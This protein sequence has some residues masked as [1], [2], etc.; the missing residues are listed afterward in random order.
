MF[1]A[2]LAAAARRD[3]KIATI[4][5]RLIKVD[6][7]QLQMGEA[8]RDLPKQIRVLERLA[9]TMETVNGAMIGLQ[10]EVKALADEHH[11]MRGMITAW[12]EPTESNP[13][14]PRRKRTS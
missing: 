13:L 7:S 6:A 2:D 4:D 1:P 5:D 11:E 3:E 12:R 9:L 8:L 14:R 10:N